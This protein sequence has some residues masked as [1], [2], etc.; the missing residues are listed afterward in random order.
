MKKNLFEKCGLVIFSSNSDNYTFKI[1]T[2]LK[3]SYCDPQPL[4]EENYSQL[5]NFTPNNMQI[6]MFKHLFYSLYHWF[7]NLINGLKTTSHA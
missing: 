7:D 4:V 1:F 5:F 3:T 2:H 6:L